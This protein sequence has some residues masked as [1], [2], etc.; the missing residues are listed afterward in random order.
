M[1]A[2]GKSEGREADRPPPFSANI[3]NGRN[4][5]HHSPIRLLGLVLNEATEQLL[6]SL[7]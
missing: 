1:G 4:Y 5:T 7:L 6:F 2:W 3:E